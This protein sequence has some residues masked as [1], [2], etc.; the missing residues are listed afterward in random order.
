MAGEEGCEVNWT[1]NINFRTGRTDCVTPEGADKPWHT[2]IEKHEIHPSPNGNGPETVGFYKKEFGLNA[3]EA[4]A[5]NAGGHSFARFN[6]RVSY[7]AYSWTRAQEDL[8]NN[9]FAR[10]VAQRPEYFSNCWDWVTGEDGKWSLV[11]DAYGNKA[12]TSWRVVRKYITKNGGPYQWFHVFNRCPASNEC[13]SSTTFNRNDTL[14]RAEPAT[15][16][17]C[18]KDLEPGMYCQPDC[19]REIQ[20]DETAVQSDMGFYFH[21][22]RDEDGMPTGCPNFEDETWLLGADGRTGAKYRGVD[23]SKET[24][25]PDGEPLYQIVE[26]MA[27]SNDNLMKDFVPAFEKMIN[28]GYDVDTLDL[29]PAGWWN[30]VLELFQ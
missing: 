11:G 10:A 20:N 3:R 19:V 13:A 8:F 18:C 9:Q 15:P 2:A 28:N 1:G 7:Y 4:I 26:E 14:D 25:A 5:L 24:F 22:E 27:D 21:F 16:E 29:V 12:T 30:H 17:H 6:S 23:C